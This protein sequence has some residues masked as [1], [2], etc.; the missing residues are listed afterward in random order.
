MIGAGFI[1]IF[2]MVKAKNISQ[3]KQNQAASTNFFSHWL[4][5]P[6]IL[7]IIGLLFLLLILI[8]LAKSYSRKRMIE[9]EIAGI[10]QEINDFEAKNKDLKE[11]ISYL[12]SD[13]SLEEQARLNMGLKR[14]GETVAVIQD[15]ATGT[16]STTVSTANNLSNWKKW[17]R[18]FI[19]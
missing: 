10:Q 8:P 4:A 17:W 16:A 7:A 5:N 3:F 6:R 12:Q 1:F 13:A 14:P 18:Y 2:F 9:N 15:K 19:N 11:M